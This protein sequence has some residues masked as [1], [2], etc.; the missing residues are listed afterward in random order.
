M[1]ISFFCTEGRV[2]RSGQVP[3]SSPA[4]LSGSGSQPHTSTPLKET[5]TPSSAKKGKRSKRTGSTP[6]VGDAYLSGTFSFFLSTSVWIVP[7][8]C[9]TLFLNLFLYLDLGPV[10]EP[11]MDEDAIRSASFRSA[12]RAAVLEATRSSKEEIARLRIRLWE[13]QARNESLAQVQ[14]RLLKEFQ[15]SEA[16]SEELEER[17]LELVQ[18]Q[19]LLDYR[20]QGAEP[21]A[22]TSTNGDASGNSFSFVTV[23]CLLLL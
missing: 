1:P 10:M 4:V 19:S 15:A 8:S 23:L 9:I 7:F 2:S 20:P 17:L 12:V 16:I 14:S 11:F 3:G 21:V 13:V 5:P 22:S 6:G 18:S